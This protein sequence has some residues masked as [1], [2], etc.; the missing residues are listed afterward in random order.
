MVQRSAELMLSSIY[1]TDI[2]TWK[3]IEGPLS[4]I[5]YSPQST[6]LCIVFY[7]EY[8]PFINAKP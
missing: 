4:V 7:L 6:H 3:K 5:I 2:N 8:Q 1:H